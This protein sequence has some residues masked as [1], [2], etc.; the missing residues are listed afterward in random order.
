M[1]I[2]TPFLVFFVWETEINFEG[3]LT[4]NILVIIYYTLIAFVKGFLLLKVIYYFSS[5]SVSFLIISESITGSITDIIQFFISPEDYKNW[6]FIILL[7][8]AVVIFISMFGTLVY[9]EIIVIKKWGMD[10]N[11]AKE[12]SER[13]V[14]ELSAIKILEDNQEEQEQEHNDEEK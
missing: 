7:I 12:I 13:S 1:V 11:V 4:K 8:E 5:Q 9:D 2:V 14:L 10:F 3:S 6:Y